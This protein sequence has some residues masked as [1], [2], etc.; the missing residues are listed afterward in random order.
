M[1][2]HAVA[3]TVASILAFA[4]ANIGDLI[5]L[6]LFFADRHFQSW[7]VVLGQ[8]AG[9]SAVI[10]LCL[11][12]AGPAAH[13]PHLLIRAFG[14]VPIAVGLHKLLSQPLDA[15]AKRVPQKSSSTLKV[16]AVAGI[17]FADCSDNL[18]VFTP[19]YIRCSGGG[20]VFVTLIFLVLIGAWCG[21]ARFL[22]R[23]RT[24]GTRIR[25]MADLIA[26]WALIG[27]GLFIL[28]AEL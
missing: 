8:Y 13:L 4:A 17:S 6:M 24:L 26:P 11:L 27:L 5:V 16:F 25:R 18:A 19:L 28:G 12:A 7:Q 20:K 9:V 3:L 23:H 10:G 21:I 15:E 14:I 2:S 1:F 22:T